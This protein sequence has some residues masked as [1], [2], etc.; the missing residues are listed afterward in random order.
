M[1]HTP[2]NAEWFE[3]GIVT[4][5]EPRDAIAKAAQPAGREATQ[6][7]APVKSL[8]QA[9]PAPGA[10]AP[11][12]AAP[13]VDE[14]ADKLMRLARLYINNRLYN[15]AREKLNEIVKNHPSSPPAVEAKKLLNEIGTK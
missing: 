13:V 15:K 12:A 10:A 5:D 14:E 1:G 9:T 8:K 7:A 6:A 3:K 11:G 2:P 4:L